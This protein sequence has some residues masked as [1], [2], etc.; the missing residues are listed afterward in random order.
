[1]KS[2]FLSEARKAVPLKVG[3]LGSPTARFSANFRDIL[4]RELLLPTN[5]DFPLAVVA[6]LKL[7]RG[8]KLGS[9]S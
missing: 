9:G 3:R 2:H 8:M 4:G 7:L 5:F 1:M 6:R